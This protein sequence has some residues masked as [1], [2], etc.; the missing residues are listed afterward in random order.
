MRFKYV[1]SASKISTHPDFTLKRMHPK[2][3][4]S[5]MG[6]I[7]IGDKETC[8]VHVREKFRTKGGG[9]IYSVVLLN[10]TVKRYLPYAFRFS[11]TITMVELSFDSSC[12]G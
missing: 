11:P 10:H 2:C 3:N 7:S 4:Q 1:L 6:C 5:L 8:I 9:H 12:L